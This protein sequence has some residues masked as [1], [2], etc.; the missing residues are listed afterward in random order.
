MYVNQSSMW[1]VNNVRAL[2]TS[3][4]KTAMFLGRFSLRLCS[5]QIDTSGEKFIDSRNS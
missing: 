2:E 5:L 1:K 4:R 3:S